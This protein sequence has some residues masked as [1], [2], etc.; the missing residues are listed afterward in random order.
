MTR[1]PSMQWY[2]GDHLASTSMMLRAAIGAHL[3]M[4]GT[5]WEVGP[6]PDSRAALFKAMGLGP[7]DPPFDQIWNEIKPRWR[8]T[9]DG[10][11]HPRVERTRADRDAYVEIQR[12]KGRLGGRKP[13]LSENKATGSQTKAVATEN[14]TSPTPSPTSDLRSPYPHSK[15]RKERAPE[16]RAAHPPISES[17]ID[18]RAREM[19]MVM[20]PKLRAEFEAQ[21]QLPAA[22]ARTYVDTFMV[23]ALDDLEGNPQAIDTYDFWRAAWKANADREI[24]AASRAR[25]AVSAP[26]IECTCGCEGSSY[27][28]AQLSGARA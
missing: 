11:V 9:P 17:A 3:T 25:T 15:A 2:W 28:H 23:T 27:K 13:R 20:Y 26:P 14:G 24:V 21:T 12:A 16:P 4:V 19:G 8:L 5:S 22:K 6:I 10:W 1:R 7:D 18:R